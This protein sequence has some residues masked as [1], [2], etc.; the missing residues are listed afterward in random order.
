[1]TTRNIDELR[2]LSALKKSLY[3]NSLQDKIGRDN[4]QFQLKET[5]RP[6]LA[7]QESQLKETQNIV[8]KQIETAQ[9]NE[10]IEQKEATK[11]LQHRE[12]I[13]EIKRQPLIIPLIKYLADFSKVIK[14]IMGESDGRNLT[15]QEQGVL[16]ELGHVDDRILRLLIKYYM[17][18]P[19]EDVAAKPLLP[20]PVVSMESH[21]GDIAA[22]VDAPPVYKENEFESSNRDTAAYKKRMMI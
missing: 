14:V 18:K 16:R 13:A 1:M 6:L 17:D 7:G 15:G 8:Q 5:F 21:P 9:H 20:P 10:L 2:K 4:T 11:Q 19:D 12:L 22:K 3:A